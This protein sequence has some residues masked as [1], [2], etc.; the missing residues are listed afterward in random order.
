MRGKYDKT[1]APGQVRTRSQKQTIVTPPGGIPSIEICEQEMILVEGKGEAVLSE[2]P[3]FSVALTAEE[4]AE[5]FPLLS[6]ED[7]SELGATA[8]GEQAM[9][10][11]YSFIRKCQK[12]RDAAQSTP[13]PGTEV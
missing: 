2:T 12:R 7:D 8:T 10:A 11:Y 6:L 3:A 4:L 1:V 13:E 9:T 5:S